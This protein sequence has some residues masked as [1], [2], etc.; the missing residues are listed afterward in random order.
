MTQTIRLRALRALALAVLVGFSGSSSASAHSAS[1]GGA[2]FEEPDV[3]A[4]KCGTG[5]SAS[6]PRGFALRLSGEGLAATRAVKFLGGR[7]TRDDRIARPTEKSPHRV[8]VSVPRSARSGPLR[9]ITRGATAAG[10]RIRVLSAGDAPAA[11]QAAGGGVFPV[12]GTHDYGT[13]I[14]GFGGGRGHKGQ[15]V[16]AKCG[17]PLVAA[18]GGTVTFQKFHE[19]AGNYVVVKADDGTGQAYMHLAAPAT[20]KQGQ[21]VTAGQPIGEVGET[22]RASGCHLHFE[23]WTAPGW[24]EGGE[25]IDPLPTLR[26]WDTAG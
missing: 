24:Y 2:S 23:L 18:L 4:I 9:V 26:R 6:C 8:L 3:S 10:P 5:D 16:F 15:D 17:T 11:T 21:R 25:P 19:R 22:G 1:A 13:E 14:N 12:Q 20:V 7:G